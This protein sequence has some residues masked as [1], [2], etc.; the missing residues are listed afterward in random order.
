MKNYNWS[1][2]TTEQIKELFIKD[3]LFTAKQLQSYDDREDLVALFY[4][5]YQNE[6]DTDDEDEAFMEEPTV[7]TESNIEEN[8][9]NPQEP[10]YDSPE[11]NN[12]VLSQLEPEEVDEQGNPYLF[13]LRRLVSH[14]LGDIIFS[15]PIEVK[16]IAPGDQRDPGWS[17]VTYKIDI[18]WKKD[19]HQLVLNNKDMLDV[20]TFIS[21]ADASIRN[22]KAPFDKYPS[23]MAESR[24]E[25]RALRKALSVR[26]VA[27]EELD[28][29]VVN[30]EDKIGKTQITLINAKCQQFKIDVPK[31]VKYV[32]SKDVTV[33]DMKEKLTVDDG[34]ALIRKF[35]EFQSQPNTIPAE[36][37]NESIS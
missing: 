4:E 33:D 2:Y 19:E 14:L 36:V 20:R 27:H 21:N 30:K 31:F 17:V 28:S 13:G 35:K 9:N 6:E 34:A 37:K 12:F 24:A 29:V 11:W 15:G 8:T 5:K 32:L 3:K 16:A 25:G 23:A 10:T 7:I 1:K 22:L 18:R 26:V